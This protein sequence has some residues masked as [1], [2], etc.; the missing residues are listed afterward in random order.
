[1]LSC[2]YDILKEEAGTVHSG[3][4]KKV[5]QSVCQGSPW[6]STCNC[7][8]VEFT[9]WSQ[10]INTC[11]LNL[12][13][14]VFSKDMQR[15][16]MEV[17]VVLQLLVTESFNKVKAQIIGLSAEFGLLCH[18]TLGMSFHFILWYVMNH[19]HNNMR[20]GYVVGRDWAC[21]AKSSATQR[22]GN[23]FAHKKWQ[24]QLTA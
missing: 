22:R 21:C 18:G 1:M 24:C 7:N 6:T 11:R 19:A 20:S 10:N 16:F 5:Y 12:Q 2:K 3:Q 17:S 14:S 8:H 13:N 23:F 4:A 15:H 9:W